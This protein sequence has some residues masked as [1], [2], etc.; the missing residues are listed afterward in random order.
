MK[1]FGLTGVWAYV[2][3]GV[4]ALALVATIVLGVKSCKQIDQQNHNAVVNTGVVQEREATHAEV[5]NHV[6]AAHN[7][8]TN[9]T[10]ND[11]NVVCEKYDRN[12]SH[13]K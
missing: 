3:V 5:I 13:G 1:I 9:P 12:C 6:E 11:L 2:V 8:V 10:S 4:F 7:A